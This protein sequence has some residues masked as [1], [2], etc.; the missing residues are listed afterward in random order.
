MENRKVNSEF[1]STGI[2]LFFIRWWKHLAIL[3]VSA[4]ILAAIFSS[5]RF[6]TPLYESSVSMFP[7]RSTSLSHTGFG[8]NMDFLAFGEV[9]D[10]ERLLQVMGSHI[11]RDR[12]VKRFDLFKHY[13]I[14][15]NTLYP[16]TTLWGKYDEMISSRRT[17]YGAVEVSVKDKDPVMAANM[18][19]A[20]AASADSILNEIRRERAMMAYNVAVKRYNE[21]M[22]EIIMT[23]DSLRGVME[24]GIYEY[25]AQSEMIFRQL[26]KDISSNNVQGRRA[27]EQELGV[28]TEMGGKFL[29]YR[30]HLDM[31][32]RTLSTVQR[33]MQEAKVD[34]DNFIPFKFLIDEAIVAEKKSYPVRW[35]IVFMATLAAGVLGTVTLMTYDNLK[36]RGILDSR[37]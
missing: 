17:T 10:A 30:V 12:I 29:T 6:I 4:A 37:R 28:I 11:L 25:T 35:L 19:N 32:T 31:V 34:V 13:Q 8:T 3:C 5:P 36:A 33:I 26:A 21:I 2:I 1:D 23:E 9:E 22:D 15:P 16:N 7:A 20:I 14:D 24:S 27:L 18:A